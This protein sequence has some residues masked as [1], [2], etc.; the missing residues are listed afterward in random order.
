MPCQTFVQ[1]EAMEPL[2]IAGTIE[3]SRDDLQNLA[4]RNRVM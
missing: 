2:A 4:R 3:M 1:P